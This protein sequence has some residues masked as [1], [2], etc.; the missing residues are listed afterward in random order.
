M[1]TINVVPTEYQAAISASWD[2]S[3]VATSDELELDA[4]AVA[5]E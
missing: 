2:T 1:V 4:D 5:D 3:K